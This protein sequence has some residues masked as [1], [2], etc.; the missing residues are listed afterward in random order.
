MQIIFF[1][2]KILVWDKCTILGA[3]GASSKLWIHSKIFLKIL[4]NNG[5]IN[6]FYPKKFVQGKWAIL[7][8]KVAHP[9]NSGS[10]LRILFKFC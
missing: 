7:G 9:H 2:K 1:S 10:A 4:Q 3:N 5:H 8:L 6:G